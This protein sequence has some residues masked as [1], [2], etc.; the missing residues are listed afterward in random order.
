MKPAG[1]IAAGEG[2]R[3]AAA[4]PGTVKPLVPV[5]G[6]PLSDWIVR[7]LR[8]AGVDSVTLLHNSRGRAVREHLARTFPSIA[9]TFL[10][11]D[12]ASSWE[13]FRL[14]SKA[15][16]ERAEAFLMTTVDALIPPAELSRFA[17]EAGEDVAVAV[18]PFVDDEKPLWAD[19][20]DGLVCAFGDQARARRFCTSGLYQVTR[21]AA[22]GMPQAA[23]YSRLR[24]FWSGLLARDVPVRAVTLAKTVDVDRP[25][26]V[27]EA[28]R[29]LRS[30]SW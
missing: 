25:E 29:Y 8:A 10:E 4:H 7:S 28:E 27:R 22:A 5:A 26:D 15:L 11:A 9:W 3:L 21:T 23:A 12:T 19:V 16:A 14:V 13:S 17:R 30:V 20:D 6:A 1:I 2:S 24:D 18:T